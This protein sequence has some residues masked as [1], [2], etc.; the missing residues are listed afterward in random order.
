[1]IL[2]GYYREKKTIFYHTLH[3][4]LHIFTSGGFDNIEQFI[5]LK[6]FNFPSIDIDSD[7]RIKT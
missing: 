3:V 2:L 7:N 6:I 5:M 4:H 1:M